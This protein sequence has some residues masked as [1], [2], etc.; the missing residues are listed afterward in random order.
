M[1]SRAVASSAI[2]PHAESPDG[3]YATAAAAL[4]ALALSLVV[5]AVMGASLTDLRASRAA[6]AR[7][8]TEASLD[9]V[10]QAAV[11]AVLEAGQA[12]R[13]RWFIASEQGPVEVLAEPEAP[14]LSLV[15]AAD[16]DDS[17]LAGLGGV[18]TASIKSRLRALALSG[19]D[20]SEVTRIAAL[21]LWRACAS[22]LISPYGRADALTLSP[23]RQPAA[24]RFAWRA[25]EVWRLRALSPDGWAD[26]RIVRLTGD[27]QHP[28]A[29]IERMFVRGQR[30]GEPCGIFI[31]GGA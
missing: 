20:A 25:G 21:P 8:T 1:R 17:D 22:S 23:A 27:S 12:G 13:L 2:D 28:A 4:T 19:A 16:L 7:T 24:G 3:G 10:Q 9:G 11:V 30:G 6:L 31:D 18:S 14:K 26:D 29:I 5:S 15:S